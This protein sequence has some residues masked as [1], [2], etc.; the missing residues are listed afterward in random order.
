MSAINYPQM[1]DPIAQLFDA[2]IPSPSWLHLPNP[3]ARLML[4]RYAWWLCE[5]IHRHG[6]DPDDVA[7][8][9]A[10]RDRARERLAE[11]VRHR[12]CVEGG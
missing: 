5:N 11:V 9:E 7:L 2:R 8:V 4:S 1:S 6:T 12:Q 10:F 3:C